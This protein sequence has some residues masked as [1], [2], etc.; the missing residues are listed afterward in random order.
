MPHPGVVANEYGAFAEDPAAASPS[1]QLAPTSGA[2]VAR[3]VRATATPPSTTVPLAG[4]ATIAA[5]VRVVLAR[6]HQASE[7]SASHERWR[8]WVSVPVKAERATMPAAGEP[9][10]ALSP[11]QPS[12]SRSCTRAGAAPGVQPAGRRRSIIRSRNRQ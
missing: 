11:S 5:G 3:G 7:R 2:P 4:A 9:I 12:A 10:E 8:A 6:Q 1:Y